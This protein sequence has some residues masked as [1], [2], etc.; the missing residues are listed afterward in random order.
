MDNFIHG[1]GVFY[2]KSGKIYE[3]EWKNNKMFGYG[4]L[5]WP[6]GKVFEGHFENDLK[7]G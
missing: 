5:K 7:H 6:D 1:K 4:V 2:W 3:G